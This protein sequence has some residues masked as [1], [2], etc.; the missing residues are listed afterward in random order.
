MRKHLI[1]WQAIASLGLVA[2]TAACSGGGSSDC[3]GEDCKD[4][5][6]SAEG[7]D[8]DSTSSAADAGKSAG[9]KDASAPSSSTTRADSGASGKPAADAGSGA[10]AKSGAGLPCDVAEVVSSRCSLCHGAKPAYGAP[11]ALVKAADFQGK[12]TDGRALLDVIKEKVNATDPRNRMPPTSATALS[13]DELS[14]LNDWLDQGAPGSS[15]TCTSKPADAGTGASDA[16]ASG[17]VGDQECYDFLAHN[18][19]FKTPFAVG[20]AVDSYFNFTFPAPWQGTGYAVVFRP[21]IDN[22]QA[23]HHFLLFEDDVAGTPSG[24]TPSIGAH[25]TGQLIFGWAPGGEVLDLPAM[26]HPD[27]GLEMPGDTTYTIEYHYNSNDPSAKDASGVQ[28]CIIHDKPANVAG[29]TWLGTDNLVAPSTDWEGTCTPTS[30]EPIHIIGV[31]PHMHKT[32]IHMKGTIN[33]ASG[34]NEVFQDADFDFNFQRMYTF[35]PDLV[36]MP[37]DSITT[38]CTYSQPMTFG[39]STND[40]MCYMFTLAYPAGALTD[41]GLWGAFAHGGSACLG[42]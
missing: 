27:V 8:D 40:E 26:G 25:P 23:I 6:S 36:L 28:V 18:G 15:E 42:M 16:G 7:S 17:P 24:A 5:R 9:K 38:D 12:A 39:E 1:S 3:S 11:M 4:S 34:Q 37:G 22:M 14:L 10:G 35:M 29:I 31:T 2:L 20:T 13:Q 41:D 32:G 19:D 30:N 21:K 33:R